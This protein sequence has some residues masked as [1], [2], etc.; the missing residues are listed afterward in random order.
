MEDVLSELNLRRL[1][2][3]MQ[4]AILAGCEYTVE[5]E[6]DTIKFETKNP[7]KILYDK[8]GLAEAVI[9]LDVQ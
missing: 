8:N 6:G 3:E 1:P 4:L 2:R 5:I 7:V 9:E